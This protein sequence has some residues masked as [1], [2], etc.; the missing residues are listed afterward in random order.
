[1]LTR[2]AQLENPQPAHAAFHG[3]NKGNLVGAARR[4]RPGPS[5]SPAASLP[6][7]EMP[8]ER[9]EAAKPARSRAD[10]A[11]GAAS[12]RAVPPHLGF[13]GTSRCSP[14]TTGPKE[15]DQADAHAER[16]IAQITCMRSRTSRCRDRAVTTSILTA[17]EPNAARRPRCGTA[18]ISKSATGRSAQPSTPPF[19]TAR[20]LQV[21]RAE[22][23]AEAMGNPSYEGTRD[24]LPPDIPG[25]APA[26][27]L[28][29]RRGRQM[30]HA[31]AGI[32]A[33]LQV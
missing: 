5:S 4:T 19:A 3:P 25:R 10:D 31:F 2:R 6:G 12:A 9:A 24:P 17:N 7:Q 26:C 1:M 13:T 27:L 28:P 18:A 11:A 21:A 22:V 30:Q 33:Q 14:Q 16:V 20:A 32:S 15:R 29:A 8:P 23:A